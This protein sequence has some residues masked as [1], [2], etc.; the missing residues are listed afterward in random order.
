MIAVTKEQFFAV[1]NPRDVHPC[2]QKHYVEWKMCGGAGR[3]L[4][5]TTP[6]YLHPE[7]EATY[8]VCEEFAP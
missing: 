4:G 3:T 2:P 6:G 8:K 7:R 5:V 1:M